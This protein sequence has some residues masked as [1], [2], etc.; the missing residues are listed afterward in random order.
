VIAPARVAMLVIFLAATLVT[1]VFAPWAYAPLAGWGAAAGW[2]VGWVWLSVMPMGASQTEAHATRES[3]GRAA[4]ELIILCSAVASLVGVGYVLVR[5]NSA[6]GA[7]QSLL[8]AL[9]I[10]SVVL[11]WFAIHTL[12]TLRYALL[13][14]KARDRPIDFKSQIPPRYLDFAYLAFTLGMTFQVSDTDLRTPTL[15]ATA[16][17]HALVSYLFGAVILASMINL[18]AGLGSGSG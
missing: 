10:V 7:Q 15:R 9:G 1:G 17:R 6:H 14:Y 4:S 3:P 2:F 18:V 12:F 8:A 11:S 5:A 16:L 13:Y